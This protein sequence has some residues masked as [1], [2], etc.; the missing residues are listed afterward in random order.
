MAFRRGFCSLEAPYLAFRRVPRG[1]AQVWGM[2]IFK[3][4]LRSLNFSRHWGFS[5]I[6]FGAPRPLT[7]CCGLR[8]AWPRRGLAKRRGPSDGQGVVGGSVGCGQSS[9]KMRAD[10]W[11]SQWDLGTL[12]KN[13]ISFTV[14]KS[15]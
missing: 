3:R 9:T 13:F 4:N 5:E 12:K 7:C 1:F 2:S 14:P 6:F 11:P 15:H 8:V 10:Q